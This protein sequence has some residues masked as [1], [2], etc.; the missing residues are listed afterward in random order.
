MEAIF[1]ERNLSRPVLYYHATNGGTGPGPGSLPSSS[2]RPEQF[3]ARLLNIYDNT[4]TTAIEREIR[5][6]RLHT[7]TDGTWFYTAISCPRC[8]FC[9]YYNGYWTHFSGTEAGRPSSSLVFCVVEY[10]LAVFLFRLMLY[11]MLSTCTRRS[12]CSSWQNVDRSSYDKFET[13]LFVCHNSFSYVTY[14]TYKF[15]QI[16]LLDLFMTS[17]NSKLWNT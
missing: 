4:C 17:W 8:R 14:A 6:R 3:C 11:E 2:V 5:Y 15:G 16:S 13:I 7:T 9:C 10:L 12:S 1:L